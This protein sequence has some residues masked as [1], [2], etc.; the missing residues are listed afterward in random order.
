MDKLKWLAIAAG[1]LLSGCA[2]LLPPEAQRR[3]PQMAP[4]VAALQAG[5][6]PGHAIVKGQAFAKTV[7][8]DVKYG[9]GNIIELVASTPYSRECNSIQIRGYITRCDEALR[10]YVRYAT[11]DAQGNFE[12]DDVA[13]GDYIMWTSITWGV[14]SPYGVEMTGGYVSS[15]VFVTSDTDVKTVYMR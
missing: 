14:P 4:E 6:R 5:M 3:D 1:L 11:A 7:G 10:P 13:P 8:G 2:A 12:F 9:A 15:L